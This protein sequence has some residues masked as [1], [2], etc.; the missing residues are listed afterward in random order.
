M[1]AE[2]HNFTSNIKHK[3][4]KKGVVVQRGIVKMVRSEVPKNSPK[5][6]FSKLI[7]PLTKIAE[8]YLLQLPKGMFDKR[9][10][11]AGSFFNNECSYLLLN[12]YFDNQSWTGSIIIIFKRKKE[13]VANNQFTS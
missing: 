11:N 2:V 4:V 3:I 12:T 5:E 7:I 10:P 13:M 6:A 9:L 8:F 1:C